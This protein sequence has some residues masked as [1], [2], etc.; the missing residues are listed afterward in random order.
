MCGFDEN[1]L[2]QAQTHVSVTDLIG[3]IQHVTTD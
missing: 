1:T 3:L 2:L